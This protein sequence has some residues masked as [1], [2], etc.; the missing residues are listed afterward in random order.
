MTYFKAKLKTNGN[1]DLLALDHSEQE[2]HQHFTYAD[3]TKALL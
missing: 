3:Y 1:K 2:M